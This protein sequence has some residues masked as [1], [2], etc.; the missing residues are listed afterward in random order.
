MLVFN[1]MNEVVRSDTRLVAEGKALGQQLD[2]AQLER[3]AD[4]PRTG[5]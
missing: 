1:Q 5:C 4:E 2:K 3:I